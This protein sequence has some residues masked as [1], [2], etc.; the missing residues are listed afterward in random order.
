MAIGRQRSNQA[1][2]ADAAFEPGTSVSVGAASAVVAAA[3]PRR[4]EITITNDH[5][6]NILYLRLGASTALV[7]TGIRVNAAGGS[8]TTRA[9]TGEIRGIASGASTTTLVTEI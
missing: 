2:Q 9:Y 6:S 3:N 8:Y 5:A 4:V 1:T 7:N